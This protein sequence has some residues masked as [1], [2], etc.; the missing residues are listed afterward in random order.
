MSHYVLN[1]GV[2]G[3]IGLWLVAGCATA[4]GGAHAREPKAKFEYNRIMREYRVPAEEA[5]NEVERVAMLD[6]VAQA[7]ADFSQEYADVPRW[8]A[9]ALRARGQIH[10]VRGQFQ[11]ALACFEQVG[12]RYPQE[13]WEVIQAWK[14]AADLLWETQHRGE[15]V[16]YYRQIVQTYD[17]PGQ[18]PM[19]GTLVDIAR[20][21]L[22]ENQRP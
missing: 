10:V 19:F 22:Q 18:P 4:P 21:R 20:S 5:T 9:A 3:M 7:Y 16:L 2:A 8:A 1:I 13:H 14:E 15:A 17:R 12:Q 11:D 6:Q